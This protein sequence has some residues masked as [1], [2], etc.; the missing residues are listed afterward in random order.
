MLSKDLTETINLIEEYQKTKK[1][2]N[3]YNKYLSFYQKLKEVKNDFNEF[4]RMMN[5]I[6]SYNLN[7]FDELEFEKTIEEVNEILEKLDGI[8]VPSKR[9][10]YNLS[11]IIEK[12]DSRLENE[13]QTKV[14]KISRDNLN[15]LEIIKKL[16][17]NTNQ[18]DDIK[19]RI[20]IVKSKWPFTE[21]ELQNYE[22]AIEDSRR[23]IEKLEIGEDGEEIKEFLRLVSLGKATL[24]DINKQILTWIR[25]NGF[26][27]N[28]E[29][30]FSQKNKTKY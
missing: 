13:W 29:V 8:E 15:T 28:L 10:L 9:K 23:L 18:I 7:I 25:K 6:D 12:K 5:L 26:D 17:S 22:K 30:K 11:N 1:Q 24:A 16:L 2:A 3:Y 20:D 27:Q 21:K 4:K 14:S 19:S